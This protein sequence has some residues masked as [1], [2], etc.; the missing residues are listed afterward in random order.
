MAYICYMDID[1]IKNG[2][3]KDLSTFGFVYLA[4]AYTHLNKGNKEIQEI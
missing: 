3:G 1:K 4:A 2:G